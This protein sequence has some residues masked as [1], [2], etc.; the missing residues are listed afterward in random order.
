MK[1]VKKD[2]VY[3]SL[4]LIVSFFMI[5][6]LF[7]GIETYSLFS[8]SLIR[9]LLGNVF[10]AVLISFITHFFKRSI[11]KYINI[12]VVLLFTIYS[13]LQVG[14]HNFLGVYMSFKTSSQFGAVTS[15]IKDFLF[16]FKP[17]F[18]ILFIPFIIFILYYVFIDKRVSVEKAKRKN[19]TTL[20]SL[21]VLIVV[22]FLYYLSITIPFLQNSYQMISNK[23]LFLTASNPSIAIDQ[24][25]CTSYLFLDIKSI[26]NPVTIKE[27]YEI[28]NV[29][30]K[31]LNENSRVFD[32]SAWRLLINEEDNSELNY[33]NNYLLNNRSTDK[34]EYTG[35]FEGKNLIIIMMESVNDIFINPEY[36]PNFYKMLNEGWYFENNYSP[37]NSCATMNNEFSGMT[38][39]YSIYNTCTASKYK[40]N[41]YNESIFNLFNDNVKNKYVTFSAHNYTEAYYPRK[42]IHQNMGSMKYYGAQDLDIPYSSEYINWSNDD[43][44]FASILNVIDKST[45]KNKNFMTWLTTVS[46][47]QPYS[48]SS[49]QGD[50]YYDL[51]KDTKYPSDVRRYMSKLKILDDGL[52]LLLEGLKS[53]GILDDTVILLYGDHYPYG[54]SKNNLNK[55]LPYDTEEDMNAERVPLVIY[56]TGIEH[57][58]FSQYTTYLN[59]TPT[60]ANLFN[61]NYDPRLYLGVDLFSD[62]YKSLAV[63]ADGSWKNEYAYYDVSKMKIKY[64]SDK[65]YTVDEIKEINE[66]IDEHIT[67][68]NKIISLDYFN[69]YSSKIEEYKIKAKEMEEMTC[70][71]E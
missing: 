23:E 56:N 43:D 49:I 14:F 40:D 17:I 12:F 24:F 54:L 30:A 9:I 65:E 34:N 16:S 55:V 51:T 29:N 53:R 7:R 35:L 28:K 68:S 5:E 2:I 26:V 21:L 61:L 31:N 38:S 50:K 64:Y 60:I 18:L 58:V 13:F 59:I 22:G 46:S 37:R 11:Q 57:K 39:L 62:S 33:I 71:I 36:Y 44:F 27:E 19:L 45:E 70:P 20:Y 42:R 47:H 32:D 66:T 48:V 8:F 52:G 63:F 67:L 6:V 69:Y 3:N 4:V 10:I 25:G 41:V 15:Y 1:V